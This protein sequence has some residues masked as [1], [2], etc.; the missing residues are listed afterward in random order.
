[1]RFALT[2]L[3]A[4]HGAI[5]VLGFFKWSKLAEVPQLSGRT[6]FPSSGAADRTFAVLWLAVALTLVGA[7]VLRLAR[8][9]AWWMLALPGLLVSQGLILL[10][11][12]DA[13][14]GSVANMILLLPA[15]VAGANAR[16]VQGVETEN[17]A[18]LARATMV[19]STIVEAAELERL[20]ASVRHWLVASGSVGRN[21]IGKVRLKQ[22]GEL[23]TAPSA[24]WMPA[25][26]EQ[27]F[28]IDPPGFVWRVDATVSGVLPIA[29]R[30][31]YVNGHGHMLIKAASLVSIVDAADEKIDQGSLLR[32]LGEMVWFPS[33][34][35]SSYLT[36]EGID[37][38]HAKVTMR[39]AGLSVSAVYA[40]DGRGRITG[41]RAER[42][43]GDGAQAKLTPWLV[44]CT[45]WGT[46]DRIEVPIE[47][48]VAW[49]LADLTFSYYRWQITDLGYD[50]AELYPRARAGDAATPTPVASATAPRQQE[51]GR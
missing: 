5:H 47:G 7:A 18:L 21:R 17:R 14:L 31:K 32:F 12:P 20:P 2:M 1:M 22:R 33:A 39:H 34:A 44:S 27:Y 15:L 42:Y 10:A 36:W 13:K 9:D 26:A 29:G 19:P 25:R 50:R 51:A 48:D 28:S 8:N 49:Q 30:D 4:L 43:L 37:A 45:K 3:L 11:W 46:F 6:L 24:S 23:R 40:F 41:M 38:T 16:F 35:L